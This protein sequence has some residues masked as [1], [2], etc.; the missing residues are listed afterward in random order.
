VVT[1]FYCQ[2]PPHAS[3]IKEA[4][5][6]KE[7]G[8]SNQGGRRDLSQLPHKIDASF[9]LINSRGC[10]RLGMPI[11][12]PGRAWIA[13]PH[14]SGARLWTLVLSTM[15]YIQEMVSRP[16]AGCACA[17][18][19]GLGRRRRG[20][21]GGDAA[22]TVSEEVLAQF[23]FSVCF[24]VCCLCCVETMGGRR[25]PYSSLPCPRVQHGS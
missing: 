16:R 7:A 8:F 4:S 5:E 24:A 17:L 3:V 15:L 9:P 12:K 18:G 10:M 25:S 22:F 11:R 19:L 20:G 14:G 21:G 2:P 6:I 1:N 13:P 23:S